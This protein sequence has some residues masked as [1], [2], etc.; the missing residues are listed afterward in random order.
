MPQPGTY[1]HTMPIFV[2]SASAA[3]SALRLGKDWQIPWVR[4]KPRSATMPDK[5]RSAPRLCGKLPFARLRIPR[6][7][8][9]L[10]CGLWSGAHPSIRGSHPGSSP[11]LGSSQICAPS[12]QARLLTAIPRRMHGISLHL[13]SYTAQDSVGTGVWD[14]SGRP[15]GVVSICAAPLCN[16]F[17]NAAAAQGCRSF[18][19]RARF[20][21]N[22]S[23]QDGTCLASK[24]TIN[25]YGLAVQ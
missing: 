11:L 4:R 5:A 12:L 2:R 18:C 14:R 23:L 3:A 8:A 21:T 17:V 13:R 25:I 24:P 10:E 20:G 16:A 22:T 7:V 6:Q 19:A 15:Q 9:G 1:R